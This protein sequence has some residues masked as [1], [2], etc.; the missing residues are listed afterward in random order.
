MSIRF[1]LF[2]MT[3]VIFVA[4]LTMTGVTYVRGSSALNGLLNHAG[5]EGVKDTALIVEDKLD[6]MAGVTESYAASVSFA[7]IVS[8]GGRDLDAHGFFD[9]VI[10]RLSCHQTGRRI[11]NCRLQHLERPT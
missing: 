2:L 10:D 1:K 3:L 4:V 11:V 5:I 7:F 6:T 9:R 8:R